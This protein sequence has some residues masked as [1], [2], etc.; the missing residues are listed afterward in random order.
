[1]QKEINFPQAQPCSDIVASV[2]N[3]SRPLVLIVDDFDD[4]LDIYSTFLHFH[5]FNVVTATGGSEAIQ[6]A[7]QTRPAVIFM[8]LRMPEMTGAEALAVLRQDSA[9]ADVPVIAFTAH[10]LE[11]ERVTAMEMGFT[12]VLPKPCLPDDFVVVV[13]R[14]LAARTPDVA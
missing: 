6:I 12:E 5:G 9:F 3:D 8:D 1:M 14:L 7:Q 13:K 2:V 10:A 4:A 11:E